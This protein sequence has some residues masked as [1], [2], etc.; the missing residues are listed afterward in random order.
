MILESL[1]VGLLILGICL[2]VYRGAVHEFQILQKEYGPDHNW[3]EILN[4]QLPLV[5]RSLPRTWLGAW[6]RKQTEHK[7]WVLTV[8]ENGKRFRTTWNHWLKEP[9]G[10]PELAELATVAKLDT[11]LPHWTAEGFRQWAW[12]PPATPTPGILRGDQCLGV[13]KLTTEARTFVSTYGGYLELWI[14]HEGAIPANVADDLAGKNPWTQT[15]KEIPWIGEVKFIEVKL[16]P[17][18][19]IVIPKHW[20][21]AVR[22][23]PDKAAWYWTADFHT[24]ISWA[25]SAVARS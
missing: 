6:T 2:V 18:N 3:S 10:D 11:V 17:G 21:V 8:Q 4:E 1:F 15:T 22:S 14:A 5:I 25:V 20:W 16:R 23:S 24:P 12:L 7:T 13:T 19:A 9:R